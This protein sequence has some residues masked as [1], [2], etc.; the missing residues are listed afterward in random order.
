MTTVQCSLRA[1]ES[2]VGGIQPTTSLPALLASMENHELQKNMRK[3][4]TLASA[5]MGQIDQ[6]SLHLSGSQRITATQVV[7][8]GGAI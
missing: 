5:C 2:I 7:E 8:S 4:S 6:A 1:S 3:E